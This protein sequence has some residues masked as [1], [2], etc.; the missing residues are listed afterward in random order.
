MIE[1]KKEIENIFLLFNK[2][3][4]NNSNQIPTEIKYIPDYLQSYLLKIDVIQ[5]IRKYPSKNDINNNRKRLELNGLITSYSKCPNIDCELLRRLTKLSN[6]TNEDDVNVIINKLNWIKSINVEEKICAIYGVISFDYPPLELEHNVVIKTIN[7]SQ[8]LKERRN[9]KQF[10]ADILVK[11]QS[12]LELVKERYNDE[13]LKQ[14]YENIIVIIN[15][16]RNGLD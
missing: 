14:I 1:Q 12:S 2:L 11:Y 3:N 5:F 7:L 6:D 16:I 10:W 4:I 13:K 15:Q 8:K 9:D